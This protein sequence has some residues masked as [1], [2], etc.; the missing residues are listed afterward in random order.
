MEFSYNT[1]VKIAVDKLEHEVKLLKEEYLKVDPDQSLRKINKNTPT[2]VP[3][4]K[5]KEA[6][7][8]FSQW[9]N[10]EK[11]LER[12]KTGEIPSVDSVIDV[13][14]RVTGKTA[15]VYFNPSITSLTK[16]VRKCIVPTNEENVFAFFDLKAAEFA[17][18]AIF[19]QEKEAVDAYHRG[20]DIYMHYAYLFPE[21][22]ERSVIKK[23]LIANMYNKSAYS[24][25]LDLGI[26]ETQAQRLLDNVAF[27]IPRMTALK[28][29]ILAY[30]RRHNGYFCPN[31]FD[32]KDLVKIADIDEKGFNPDF[33]LSVYSQ[34]A[35]G[36]FC[37]NATKK[38]LTRVNGTLLSVFDSMLVEIK[39]ENKDRFVEWV[40]TNMSP[41]LADNVTFGKT[42]YE[43]AY[44]QE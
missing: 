16:Q 25:A 6:R 8:K 14:G 12:I 35:L 13:Q 26:T 37:Q 21:G 3:K 24:T 7:S 36:I 19:A 1:K 18:T 41:L 5:V 11:F 33:A 10:M 32:Q 27:N 9:N 38:L 43:A 39:P 44:G 4:C 23:I 17:M 30:D 34:S 40:K 2:N 28:S 31:G 29:K 42:F 22:T 15:R 20:E